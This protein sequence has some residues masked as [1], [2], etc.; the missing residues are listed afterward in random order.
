MVKK[1][2]WLVILILFV[3][4]A[5]YAMDGRF[6]LS[7]LTTINPTAECNDCLITPTS[8]EIIV[9]PDVLKPTQS[10]TQT[11]L[12]TEMVT[13][14]PTPIPSVDSTDL[15]IGGDIEVPTATMTPSAADLPESTV[16]ATPPMHF[17]IQD[18]SPVYWKN[19]VHIRK[20]CNWQGVAGQ[21]FDKSGNPLVDY[22]VK[23]TGKYG[24]TK[25]NLIGLTG[26]EKGIRYGPGGFE[27][28]LG[29]KPIDSTNRLKIQ[30]FDSA[31]VAVSDLVRFNTYSS[32]K[33]NLVIINFKAE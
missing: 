24:S 26:T 20:G 7:G 27:I 9:S 14:E 16:T 23:V 31:G 19:F 17:V 22:V 10:I 3:A 30:V 13:S 8:D 18:G 4:C 21:V 29:L 33:K 25:V 6:D 2:L 12:A 28:K 1:M 11:L 15:A 32:C 5:V